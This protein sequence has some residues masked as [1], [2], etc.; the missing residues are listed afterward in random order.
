MTDT[1]DIPSTEAGR[2]LRQH[3]EE[4]HMAGYF[5]GTTWGRIDRGIRAIEE[6][7]RAEGEKRAQEGLDT[8]WH[9]CDLDSPHHLQA[10]G[11]Q[12]AVREIREQLRTRMAQNLHDI[13][14][15][16]AGLNA[17]ESPR[18]HEERDCWCGHSKT[19]PS[20]DASESGQPDD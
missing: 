4:V 13:L 2:A 8:V 9:Y 17:S 6:Q 5:G 20:G 1:K 14:D 3:L 7:A 16:V 15:R 12:Q 11:R 10:E 19:Y 18:P